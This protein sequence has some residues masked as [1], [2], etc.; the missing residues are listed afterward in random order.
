MVGVAGVV[1]GSLTGAALVPALVPV[2]IVFGRHVPPTNSNV[3]E[4]QVGA[5]SAFVASE[6]LHVVFAVSNAEPSGH[7]GS[8]EIYPAVCPTSFSASSYVVNDSRN[9]NT[10]TSKRRR[11]P[12]Q[13]L[14]IIVSY[15]RK[16]SLCPTC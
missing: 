12:I 9:Q 4:E 7:L 1:V 11:S 8:S 5:T 10:K 13:S 16:G 2:G 14:F 6:N 3:V 15:R